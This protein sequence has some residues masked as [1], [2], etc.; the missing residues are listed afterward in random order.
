[1]TELPQPTE[2]EIAQTA[3]LLW[4]EEGQPEGQAEAHWHRAR[5]LLEA[6]PSEPP[7]PR[8]SAK[9]SAGTTVP[10]KSRAKKPADPNA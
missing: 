5:A 4:L 2:T 1:M 10:R 7:K 3:Y 9:A 8:R 6:L